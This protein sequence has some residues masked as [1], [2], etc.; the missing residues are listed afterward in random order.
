MSRAWRRYQGR[1]HH[2]GRMASKRDS[3]K[4]SPVIARSLRWFAL[5]LVLSHG[6]ALAHKPS[7]SYLAI[8]VA[9]DNLVLKFD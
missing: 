1:R 2:E 5:T 7:D 4:G 9:D 8:T 3:A 6:A